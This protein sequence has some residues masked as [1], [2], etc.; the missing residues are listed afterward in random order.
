MTVIEQRIVE[1]LNSNGF[2]DEL[3]GLKIEESD[4]SLF[5]RLVI[6]IKWGMLGSNRVRLEKISREIA[7]RE[8]I[9]LVRILPEM[10]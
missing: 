6:K 4:N 7:K 1:E 9:S 10:L 5:R 8:G 2:R 3:E